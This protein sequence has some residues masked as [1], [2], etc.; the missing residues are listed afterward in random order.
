MTDENN[1]CPEDEKCAEEFKLPSMMEMAKNLMSDG[2]KIVG[3]AFS[4]NKT[5]VSDD[6]RESRWSICLEC[7]M[8]QNNRCT[9]CGCFM[10]VKTALQTSKCPID[11]W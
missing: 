11:K 4:G 1:I 9:Q 7:P 8:L 5:V 10:K 3:N 6:V 2:V